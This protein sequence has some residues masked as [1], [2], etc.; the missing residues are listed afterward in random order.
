MRRVLDRESTPLDRFSYADTIACNMFEFLEGV[1]ELVKEC[2]EIEGEDFQFGRS[3]DP[4]GNPTR[5]LCGPKVAAS[6]ITEDGETPCQLA[7]NRIY[8]AECWGSGL[9]TAEDALR[10]AAQLQ[11]CCREMLFA[12]P[13]L[14]S[15]IEFKEFVGT[16]GMECSG[17]GRARAGGMLSAWEKGALVVQVFVGLVLGVVVLVFFNTM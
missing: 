10:E 2:G 6:R 3:M 5:E 15:E 7:I 12:N 11:G 4:L 17:A 1:N 14:T 16:L 9:S 8:W 13:R